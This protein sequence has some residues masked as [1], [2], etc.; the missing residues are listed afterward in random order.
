M[1]K[2]LFMGLILAMV[3]AGQAAS[4]APGD[5]IGDMEVVN[6]DRYVSMRESPDT[7]SDRIM[8]VSLG[9]VVE[10]CMVYNDEFIYGE[11]DMQYGYIL[12][13]YLEP[14]GGVKT[15]D[16]MQVVNCE[17]YV[18]LF[19]QPD[20]DSRRILKVPL[21]EMVENCIIHDE[22]F[23]YAEY[24]GRCGFIL[25]EY[26]E[27]ASENAS[28]IGWEYFGD[29]RVHQ[30]D[31]WVS[32]YEEPD[33]DSERVAKVPLGEIVRD[34]YINYGEFIYGEYNGKKG[35]ILGEYLIEAEYIGYEAIE[36]MQ[37]SNCDSWVSLREEATTASERLAKVPKNTIV[38]VMGEQSGYYHVICDGMIGFIYQEYLEYM[39][40]PYADA[41]EQLS[42]SRTWLH[43]YDA[44]FGVYLISDSMYGEWS[45]FDEGYDLEGLLYGMPEEWWPVAMVIP[46]ERIAEIIGGGELYLIVPADEYAQV[47]VNRLKLGYDGFTGE[48]EEVLY[49][50]GFGEPILVRCNVYELV[51][52]CEIVMTDS[53]GR[54]VSWYPGT[55]VF[56]HQVDTGAYGGEIVD[57][58]VYEEE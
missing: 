9:S 11:F 36:Y 25:S 52:D 15:F 19:S 29:L 50:G 17:R 32:M 10:D 34:C 35:F 24:D 56:G 3:L 40:L 30:C 7:D 20:T 18:S 1:K 6:C 23:T 37:V 54:T 16:Y 51:S 45:L 33:T 47:C 31:S 22:E 43:Y 12:S 14:C 46:P 39:D 44:A 2:L 21:G 49:Q 5:Y 38:E 58:T 41:D 48:I 55:A 8:K 57:F 53:E 4:A 13:E 27:P 42:N 28:I 26:L